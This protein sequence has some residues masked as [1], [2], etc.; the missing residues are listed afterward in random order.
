MQTQ[1]AGLP[2]AY[3][4]LPLPGQVGMDLGCFR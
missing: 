4:T 1:K 3:G 2:L